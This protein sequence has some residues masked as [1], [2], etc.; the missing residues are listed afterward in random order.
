MQRHEH[1]I[2]TA[3][4]KPVYISLACIIAVFK[5]NICT[6]ANLVNGV[7]LANLRRNTDRMRELCISHPSYNIIIYGYIYTAYVKICSIAD[8]ILCNVCTS[9]F[10]CACSRLSVWVC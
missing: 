3:V 5:V 8:L 7:N 2:K 10:A 6:E 1:Y 9:V 4:S